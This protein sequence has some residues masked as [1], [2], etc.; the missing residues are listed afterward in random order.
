MCKDKLR[1]GPVLNWYCGEKT[2]CTSPLGSASKRAT[3]F[4]QGMTFILPDFNYVFRTK[5]TQFQLSKMNRHSPGNNAEQY[6]KTLVA[7]QDYILN[8]GPLKI[9]HEVN[10]RIDKCHIERTYFTVW[11]EGNLLVAKEVG[12]DEFEKPPA[13]AVTLITNIL[14]G[15]RSRMCVVLTVV[16]K[17][18]E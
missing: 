7:I 14:P 15:S 17:L 16:V 11:G 8:T 9:E 1:K 13:T 3:Y 6:L 5:A 4:R 12:S 10:I 18:L 2:I